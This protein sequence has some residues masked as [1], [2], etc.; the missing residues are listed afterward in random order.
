MHLLYLQSAKACS[1]RSLQWD[2][3]RRGL[4]ALCRSLTQRTTV[5][6]Q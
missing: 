3:K 6:L 5:H 1:R 4:T 2:E